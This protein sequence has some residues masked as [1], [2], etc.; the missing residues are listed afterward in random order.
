MGV[1]GPLP[2]EQGGRLMW[3]SGGWGGG[4]GGWRAG[5]GGVNDEITGYKGGSPSSG[6]GKH[7]GIDHEETPGGGRPKLRSYLNQDLV[8]ARFCAHAHLPYHVWCPHCR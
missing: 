1:N 8:S 3:V 4:V 7:S 2:R 5:Q 6:K